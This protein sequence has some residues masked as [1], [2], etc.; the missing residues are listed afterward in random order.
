M[1]RQSVNT[2]KSTSNT[3]VSVKYDKKKIKR[4]LTIEI[5]EYL[6]IVSV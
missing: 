6:Q 2:S 5:K 4:V 1:G 3:T